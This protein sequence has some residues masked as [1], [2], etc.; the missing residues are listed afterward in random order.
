MEIKKI[1]KL[2]PIILFFQ[3]T[4]LTIKKESSRNSTSK[5]ST[6]PFQIIPFQ[7]FT[8]SKPSRLSI[9]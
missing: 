8:S 9:E 3:L 7:K 2:W 6:C 5:R 4:I 1:A